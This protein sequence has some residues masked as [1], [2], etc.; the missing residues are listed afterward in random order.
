MTLTSKKVLVVDD[1][2]Q[3]REVVARFLEFGEYEPI[4]ASGGEEG[5]RHLSEQKPD[6]II[7]DLL[8]PGMDGYEFCKNVR[9][10]SDVPIIML[11]GQL[12]LEQERE[13]ADSLN[14][15]VYTFTSKPL[16]MREF[17]DTVASAFES[18]GS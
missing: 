18:S 14:L 11:S 8:M 15:G 9:K 3:V 2:P 10:T 4:T 6:L 5:L 12:D 1:E 17:L 16:H 13:K 7:S